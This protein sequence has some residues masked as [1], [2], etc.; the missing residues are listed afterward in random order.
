LTDKHSSSGLPFCTPD[1]ARVEE[2]T[3]FSEYANLVQE[4]DNSG[5]AGQEDDAT[6]TKAAHEAAVWIYF[7]GEEFSS[8]NR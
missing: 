6:A 1:G 5:T 3:T 2:K 8:Q 4:T 7:C